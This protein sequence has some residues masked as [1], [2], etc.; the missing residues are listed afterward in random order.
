MWA[1][2]KGYFEDL[3]KFLLAKDPTDANVKGLLAY[4]KKEDREKEDRKKVIP[5]L[6]KLP[7][8]DQIPELKRLLSDS[9]SKRVQGEDGPKRR[10]GIGQYVKN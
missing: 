9:I 7:Q 2:T 1:E 6:S 3:E 5:E 4:L 8:D 10:T